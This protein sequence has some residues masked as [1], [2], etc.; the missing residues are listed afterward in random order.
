MADILRHLHEIPIVRDVNPL[1]G[2][3]EG[4]DTGYRD[5][6]VASEDLENPDPMVVLP[7]GVRGYSVYG[8]GGA[9]RVCSAY[10]AGG[11]GGLKEIFVREPVANG[12]VRV[13]ARLRPYGR[14]LLVVDGFR[15]ART[16]AALWIDILTR[17][18][19]Q[20]PRDLSLRE[21]VVLGLKADDT[22]SYAPVVESE[23]FLGAIEVILSEHEVEVAQTAIELGIEEREV[24]RLYLTFQGNLGLVNFELN[25]KGNTAHGNGGAID[26]F[27]YDLET[28]H[29]VNHGVPFD[30]PG[31]ISV[32]DFFEN[33]GNLDVLREAIDADPVLAQHFVEFGG[34]SVT[35]E[36][37]R[38]IQ[39]ERRMLVNAMED[40]GATYFSLGDEVG[41]CWHF[42][43]PNTGGKQ[44]GV[45][46]NS[47]NSCQ[48]ILVGAKHALRGDV[49]AN[50]SNEAGHNL[51]RE[52]IG[53]AV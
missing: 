38:Q 30:Y 42:N 11:I 9:P 25:L 18:A 39:R 21:L 24:A 2:R 51:V 33:E 13:N 32:I 36:I 46:P 41:E 34:A 4:D 16:Q 17:I 26:A 28:G 6:A 37:F 52:L 5:V 35:P 23:I 8:L 3:L 29:P 47:G 48:A 14:G 45:I 31:R 27:T 22:G 40:I 53:V 44:S 1:T 10:Y 15:S 7:Q 20:D 50:W 43:L 49:E 12:I 19:G